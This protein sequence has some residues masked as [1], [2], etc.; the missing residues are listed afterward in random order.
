M[1]T[2]I[3]GFDT[4]TTS[5]DPDKGDRIIEI[6]MQLWRFE[7]RKRLINWTQRFTNAGQ[8]IHKKAFAVHG[9]S[10]ADLVGKPKFEAHVP[11]IQQIMAKSAAMVAHNAEFDVKFLVAELLRAGSKPPA[12]LP[13]FDTMAEGMFA[14]YDTKPPSLEELCWALGVEYDRAKAHAADYD[15]DVLMQAFFNGVDRGYFDVSK[16]TNKEAA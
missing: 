7:D 1:S 9:I 6:N 13:I 12:S 8:P 4:E 15:V 2:Y 16:F 3:T 11:R 5:V 10:E 14:S